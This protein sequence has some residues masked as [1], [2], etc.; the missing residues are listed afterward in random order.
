MRASRH[1][2]PAQCVLLVIAQR[3][4]TRDPAALISYLS[5]SSLVSLA[6]TSS[7]TDRLTAVQA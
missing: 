5:K 2:L 4:L 1:P 7:G 6:S 3:V